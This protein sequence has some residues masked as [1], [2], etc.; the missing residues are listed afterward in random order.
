MKPVLVVQSLGS[1]RWIELPDVVVISARWLV[2]IGGLEHTPY[3][4]NPTIGPEAGCG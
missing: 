4:N 3:A 2:D 1:A